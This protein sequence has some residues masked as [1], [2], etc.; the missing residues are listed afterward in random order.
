MIKTVCLIYVIATSAVGGC[1]NSSVGWRMGLAGAVVAPV[2]FPLAL[3]HEARCW[4]EE[5]GPNRRRYR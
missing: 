3:V 1:I 4:S 2:L 5:Y